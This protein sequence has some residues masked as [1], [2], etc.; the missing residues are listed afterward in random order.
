[1]KD[2]DPRRWTY[3]HWYF[4]GTGFLLVVN[5]FVL[6]LYFGWL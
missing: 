4:F 1:M 2:F 6:A 3:G 5:A